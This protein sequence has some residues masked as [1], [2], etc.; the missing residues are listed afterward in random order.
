MRN[1]LILSTIL[2]FAQRVSA[3]EVLTLSDAI[4]RGVGQSYGIAIAKEQTKISSEQNTW[5]AA[6]AYPTLN[7]SAKGDVNTSFSAST[8]GA[9]VMLGTQW[10]VFNG[11][12]I[13]S[14]KS[15]LANNE[16]LIAGLEM[17]QIENTIKS[18]IG[19]YYFVLMTQ[20]S[21]D[22]AEEVFKLSKDRYTQINDA[23]ELGAKG[24]YE[25]IQAETAYLED[26]KQLVKSKLSL[27]SAII[28]LNKVMSEQDPSKSWVLSDDLALPSKSYELATMEDKMLS[29]NVS[30]KNQY[31]NQKSREIEIKQAE[32]GYFPTLSLTAGVG[33]IFN[34]TKIQNKGFSSDNNLGVQAGIS[35]SYAI[36][37]NGKT[38]RNVSIAKINQNIENVKSDE[39]KH[40]LRSSLFS[41]YEQYN[42]YHKIVD[43]A[44]RQIKVAKTNLDMSTERYKSGVINSFNF[45]DVQLR[46]T[47][48]ALDRLQ[49]VYEL[50]ML[51]LEMLQITGGI[52]NE[53]VE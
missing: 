4:Q 35:L 36:F 28:S 12:L 7:F 27:H 44:D 10:T 3:Q 8:V 39:M 20:K 9:Q 51:D 37:N 29:N 26:E 11:F 52:L 21:V 15:L 31:I 53:N 32:S 17:L 48:S 46:Y 24:T 34:G 40:L 30:L 23:V 1:I 5:G 6:G 13:K 14:T 25:L 49:N 2:F 18:I 33:D 41:L 47:Y 38:R 42:V 19:S 45:R 50:L 22:V 16:E 43:L